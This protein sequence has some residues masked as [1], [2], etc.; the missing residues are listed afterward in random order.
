[1]TLQLPKKKKCNEKLKSNKQREV[2]LQ[3]VSRNN[4]DKEIALWRL[5]LFYNS[6]CYTAHGLGVGMNK[7]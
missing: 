2:Q 6:L 4:L 5:G 1:M 7:F 3:D